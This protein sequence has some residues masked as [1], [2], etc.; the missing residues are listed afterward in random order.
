MYS[1][2]KSSRNR[3]GTYQEQARYRAGKGRVH[4]GTVQ[5]LCRPGISHI[6]ARERTDRYVVQASYRKMRERFRVSKS[7]KEARFKPYI[8]GYLNSFPSLPLQS[9]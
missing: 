3:P 7:Q 1:Q 9:R 8:L 2:V 5:A 4:P 6:W